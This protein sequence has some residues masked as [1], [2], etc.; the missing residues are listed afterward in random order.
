MKVRRPR[1]GTVGEVRRT[2]RMREEVAERERARRES[3][4]RAAILRIRRRQHTKRQ[5]F[6]FRATD[7]SR[8]T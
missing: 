5:L 7:E 3:K 1:G 2:S 6:C 4:G 8:T